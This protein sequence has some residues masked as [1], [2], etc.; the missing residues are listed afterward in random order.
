MSQTYTL[1]QIKSHPDFPFERYQDDSLAFLM[2]ELYWA[3]MFS[4]LVGEN[5]PDW[6]PL[7][8]AETDGNPILSVGSLASRRALRVIHKVNEE[9][10]PPYPSLRGEGAYYGLQAWLGSG[11]DPEGA[12]E[13]DELVLFADLG[14]NI[15]ADVARLVRLH[16]I[17]RADLETVE[18]AIYDYEARVEMPE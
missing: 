8:A 5:A 12:T 2:L 18:R 4:E 10:K 17:E 14:Q 15:E 13:L 16:C 9:H 11:M 1:A 6:V 7:Q 3:Q